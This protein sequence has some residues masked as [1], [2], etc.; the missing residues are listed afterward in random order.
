MG[1]SAGSVLGC[2]PVEGKWG[3]Q[4]FLVSMALVVWLEAVSED[5]YRG[6]DVIWLQSPPTSTLG[7]WLLFYV[8][9]LDA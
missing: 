8:V 1:G 9:T 4:T 3:V 5:G 2:D 6:A 7:M